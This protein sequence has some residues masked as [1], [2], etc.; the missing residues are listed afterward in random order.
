MSDITERGLGHLDEDAAHDEEVMCRVLTQISF[1]SG[2]CWL[3]KG[4]KTQDGYGR[5]SARGESVRAH[6]YTYELFVGKIP[7]GL[8][9]DHLCR[10]RSCVNPLH[11]E[12]VT[13]RENLLR[14]DTIPAR[15]AK[16]THCPKGHEY[17]QENT[18]LNGGSRICRQCM[19]IQGRKYR[20]ANPEKE[21]AR[22]LRYRD[23]QT[24]LNRASSANC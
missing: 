4:Q 14:G 1:T 12:P 13:N 20:Q 18:Y 5:F 2:E 6:R 9:I 3:W 7:N 10:N 11:L 15:H 8:V 23:K 16:V 17:T 22:R 19:R 24:N 21:R